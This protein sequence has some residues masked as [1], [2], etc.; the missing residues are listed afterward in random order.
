MLLSFYHLGVVE[1]AQDST[2]GATVPLVCHFSPVV[3]LGSQVLQCLP[4]YLLIVGLWERKSKK[5]KKGE[6]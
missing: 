1:A 2:K 3:A 6:Q 5:E 4:W